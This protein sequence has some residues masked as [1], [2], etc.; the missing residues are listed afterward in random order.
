MPVLPTR[1]VVCWGLS[2]TWRKPHK[3][4]TAVPIAGIGRVRSISS[5]WNRTYAVLANRKIATWLANG[6]GDGAAREQRDGCGGTDGRHGFMK[7]L[8]PSNTSLDVRRMPRP[9]PPLR[10]VAPAVGST[11]QLATAM[12]DRSQVASSATFTSPWATPRTVASASSIV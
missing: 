7:A 8:R 12:R 4:W 5:G 9:G 2:E 11:S 6:T 10:E 1:R 3:A